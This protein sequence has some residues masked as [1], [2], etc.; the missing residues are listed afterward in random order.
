[1]TGEEAKNIRDKI[2][3]KFDDFPNSQQL[4]NTNREESLKRIR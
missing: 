4:N 2:K 3:E 1:M